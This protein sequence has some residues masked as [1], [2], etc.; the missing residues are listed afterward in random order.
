MKI[1]LPLFVLAALSAC[2]APFGL[3]A[4]PGVQ[5]ADVVVEKSLV[6]RANYVVEGWTGAVPGRAGPFTLEHLLAG[7]SSNGDPKPALLEWLNSWVSVQG[8]R[9][10]PIG[11]KL[12]DRWKVLDE[13]SHLD[14]A[15]WK[16]NFANAPFRLLAIVYRPDLWKR[17][18]SG[19]MISG[20]EGRFVFCVVEE[21]TGSPHTTINFEYFLPAQTTA[22]AKAWARDWHD[23]RRHGTFNASFCDALSRITNRF[24]RYGAMSGR[25]KRS[26]L[27]QIRTNERNISESL[28]HG[29]AVWNLREFSLHP[30]TGMIVATTTKQTPAMEFAQSRT[31]V[32]YINRDQADILGDRHHVPELFRHRPFLGQQADMAHSNLPVWLTRA[33]SR[34]NLNSVDALNRFALNTCNGC[35]GIETRTEN[36]HITPRKKGAVSELSAFLTSGNEMTDRRQ[37]VADLLNNVP[38]DVQL[39]EAAM[40]KRLIDPRAN[41]PKLLEQRANRVH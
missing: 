36:Y 7:L 3:R 39:W 28:V 15:T 17:D 10:L 18:K 32:D 6:I 33:G 29:A 4:G 26:A 31:L 24:T 35:H 14:D 9:T 8:G 2:F 19:R 25:P 20:G 5:A 13:A 30:T 37:I 16:P 41:L 12:I 40:K 11:R 27:A 1:S 23:L 38:P 21:S 22:Q 34:Q